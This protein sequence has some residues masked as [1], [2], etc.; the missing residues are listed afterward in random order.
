[1]RVSSAGAD[2]ADESSFSQRGA[3][4]GL[5]QPRHLTLLRVLMSFLIGFAA[6]LVALLAGA[7]L[8]WGAG[9]LARDFRRGRTRSRQALRAPVPA[10]LRLLERQHRRRRLCVHE[11]PCRIVGQPV[12]EQWQRCFVAL[13]LAEPRYPRLKPR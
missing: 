11:P 13:P 1:M 6:S 12:V 5:H 10:S 7:L 4:R 9:A 2:R 8:A 3:I